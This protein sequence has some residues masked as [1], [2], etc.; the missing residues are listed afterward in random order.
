MRC[1]N[2]NSERIQFGTNTKSS[3]FSDGNACCGFLLMGPLGLLCG[4]CGSD[5]STE[6]FWICQDCGNKFS[7][8]EGQVAHEKEL[9]E[10]EQYSASMKIKKD[11]L[12]EYG[13][14]DNIKTIAYQKKKSSD[15]I[16]AELDREYNKFIK[17][18]MN[19]NERAKKLNK[20]V[21]GK[22]LGMGCS[23]ALVLGV[24]GLL[25]C[26]I[27]LGW[28]ALI[29]LGVSLVIGVISMFKNEVEEDELFDIFVHK[30]EETEKRF[31]EACK[32]NQEHEQM[33]EILKAFE[34]C[35][36]YESENGIKDNY[37]G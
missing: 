5:T 31:E 21:N 23:V 3:G 20:K 14:F 17:G 2:C 36:K 4:L 32:K 37:L 33:E 16:N 1:P 9:S 10:K 25:G 22:K 7:N 13:T 12:D 19:G 28:L 8:K 34:F 18:N 29:C 27:G 11:A 6:E 26:L 35:D 24:I 15:E 30:D